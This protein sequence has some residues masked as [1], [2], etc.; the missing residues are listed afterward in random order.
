MGLDHNEYGNQEYGESSFEDGDFQVG[1]QVDDLFLPIHT[2]KL[3]LNMTPHDKKMRR[4]KFKNQETKRNNM[5]KAGVDKEDE[6]GSSIE[7]RR[8]L[9]KDG[10]FDNIEATRYPLRVS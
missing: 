5:A 1:E 7:H 6:S 2:I 10:K 9:V 4:L 8:T 3:F